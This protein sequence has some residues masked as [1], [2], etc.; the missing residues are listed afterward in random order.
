MNEASRFRPF[1][2]IDSLN[3]LDSILA[4]NTEIYENGPSQDQRD[5]I[6]NCL[7]ST[8]S[9]LSENGVDLRHLQPILHAVETLTEREN[10][11]LDPIFCERIRQGAPSRSLKR[12]QQD[13]I[14]A[15][16]ANH[17]LAHNA[18]K[19]TPMKSRLAAVARLMQNSGLGDLDAARVRQARELV[20]QDASDHPASV[21]AGV[22]D[23]W[24]ERA[25]TDFGENEAVSIILPMVQQ[26]AA[27]SFHQ[28]E[29]E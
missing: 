14:I 19:S 4:K 28:Q 1:G 23:S 22:I 6:A 9:Y 20:S 10:N 18:D 25:S 16:I 7:L 29:T 13:G 21:M 8:A 12:N 5:A 3:L 27:A 2:I 15:A 24:L 26:F 17:W 11:R